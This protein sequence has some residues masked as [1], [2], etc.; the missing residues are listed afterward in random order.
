MHNSKVVELG[1]FYTQTKIATGSE[2]VDLQRAWRRKFGGG[3][4]PP[5]SRSKRS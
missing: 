1:E 3:A 5:R 4:D 2:Q